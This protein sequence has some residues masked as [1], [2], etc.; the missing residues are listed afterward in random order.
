[1][2]FSKWTNLVKVFLLRLIDELEKRINE[3]H[4]VAD[5]DAF[6]TSLYSSVKFLM[7]EQIDNL[8]GE[9][10]GYARKQV[11]DLATVIVQKLAIV[12]SS[13]VYVMILVA[14]SVIV[15]MFFAISLSL[16]LGDILGETYYGFLA[17]GLIVSIITMI[18][19][20]W[21]QKSISEKIKDFISKQI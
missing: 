3:K 18:V 11:H 6:K 10:T 9:V 4:G 17:M 15:F 5:S 2:S 16:Y 8:A 12:L 7:L 14:L 20:K 21:S 1:M 13:L 19:W